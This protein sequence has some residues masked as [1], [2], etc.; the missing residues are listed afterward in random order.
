MLFEENRILKLA[1]VNKTVRAQ[2]VQVGNQRSISESLF[3]PNSTTDIHNYSRIWVIVQSTSSKPRR[4][5]GVIILYTVFVLNI[6]HY[7][8]FIFVSHFCL[9]TIKF[10]LP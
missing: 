10:L 9:E 5:S 3:S 6:R 2:Q 7:I 4:V 1:V 8:L